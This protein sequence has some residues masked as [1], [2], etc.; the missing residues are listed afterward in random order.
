LL[1]AVAVAFAIM[2][3][4]NV[5]FPA[6]PPAPE[7][8]AEDAPAQT[9]PASG[10]ASAPTPASPAAGSPSDAP[11]AKPRGAEQTFV[12]EFDELRAEFSSW[13]GVLKSWQLLGG[14]FHV[15]GKPGVSEDLVRLADPEHRSFTVSF[16]DG[17]THAIP[18]QA[19]WRGEKKGDRELVFT[20]ES[21]QLVVTKRFRIQP[22]DYLLDLDVTVGVKSGS[23]KQGLVV[24][25]YSQQ[26]PKTRQ[27][28]GWTTQGREWVSACYVDEE[29]SQWD[30]TAVN[31]RAREERG[32][33]SWTGFLHSFFIFA[34]A[35][36]DA[37][38]NIGCR[39]FG[40]ASAPGGMGVELVYPL[41]SLEGGVPGP[42]NRTVAYLGPKYLEKLEGIAAT[43]GA[44]T[45]FEKA[46]DLGWWG[47]IAGPML[48]LLERFFAFAGSWGIAIILLTIVVK[49]ATLYWT[50]KS[51]KSM[52]EMA[53]LR[54]QLDK[55]KEKYKDD[56]QKQ[57]VET[58][59]L[60]KAHGVNPL[61]GCLP[62]LLQMPIWFA[63][64]KALSVAA[65]LYQARFLWLED[66][67]AP[68]P[69]FILPIFMTAAMLLQSRLTPTTATGA[70]QK[71]LMY[72]MPLMFGVMGFF[73]PAGLSLYIST[74]TVLT[75]LHHLY[76]RRSA[77][78]EGE[79][80]PVVVDKT[81]PVVSGRKA[82][83]GKSV[84]IEVAAEAGDDEDGDAGDEAGSKASANG[85]NGQQPRG[86][87]RGNRPGKRGGRRKRTSKSS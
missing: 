23:A 17:S 16:S 59:N 24:S 63:L 31:D 38:D 11:A 87:N 44:P 15:P 3:L 84:E 13:G 18:P 21:E 26:D 33:V 69:F 41:I 57:Q 67:T 12:M 72:G 20:W 56:R 36:I 48:W 77:E 49:L 29:L 9:A 42:P 82:S 4:W 78:R 1:L 47:F 55:L 22:Q 80:K 7:K 85:R 39:A 5:L 74:N 51:M 46:V 71:M 19:E 27:K 64:Y 66:L 60:F 37:P 40:V 73:F 62:L 75:L 45:G 70:Q 53:K 65:E 52:K 54:P 30:A 61:A 14:Q 50:H 68:D 25:L 86:P 28:A 8:K 83:G 76:M 35:P 81:E 32:A 58:M 10:Q 43:V 34:I 2:M 79:R 6:E